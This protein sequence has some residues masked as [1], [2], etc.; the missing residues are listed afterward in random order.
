MGHAPSQPSRMSGMR[1]SGP[2]IAPAATFPPALSSR[3]YC[4]PIRL[5]FLESQLRRCRWCCGCDRGVAFKRS[6]HQQKRAGGAGSSWGCRVGGSRSDPGRPKAASRRG[7]APRG[8]ASPL[9]I[10]LKEESLSKLSRS[11]SGFFY[12][13]SGVCESARWVIPRDSVCETTKGGWVKPRRQG[14]RYHDA[15]SRSGATYP[16]PKAPIR[17]IMAF[18]VADMAALANRWN[19]AG[20]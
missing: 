1:P 8:G 12:R 10:L 4:H 14:G 15:A 2:E 20:G 13:E 6:S 11:E 17:R 18:R 19:Q 5:A 7:E 9:R 3:V 16:H